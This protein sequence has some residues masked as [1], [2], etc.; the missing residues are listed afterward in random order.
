M[1]GLERIHI[2]INPAVYVYTEERFEPEDIEYIRMDKYKEL[3]A[4]LNQPQKTIHNIDYT[5]CSEALIDYLVYRQKVN[6]KDIVQI[7][8]KHFA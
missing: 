3:E 7:L 5:K 2:D 4:E 8:K 6:S 1:D